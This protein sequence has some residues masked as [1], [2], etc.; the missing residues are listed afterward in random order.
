MFTLLGLVPFGEF[1]YGVCAM[2]ETVLF[3]DGHFGEGFL[4]SSGLEDWVEAEACFQ[5]SPYLVGSY[6]SSGFAFK[7]HWR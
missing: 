4:A 6:S 2:R 5:F 7:A 1:S 3:F